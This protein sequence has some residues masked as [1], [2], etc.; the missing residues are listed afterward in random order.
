MFSPS[1]HAYLPKS[2]QIHRAGLSVVRPLSCNAARYSRGEPIAMLRALAIAGFMLVSCHAFGQ[3]A[4]TRPEFEVASIKLNKS[5]DP[6]V[7][8]MP[9]RGGRF[10]ATNIPLKFL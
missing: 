5:A 4:A 1:A 3:S 9:A 6:R 10:T 2:Q 7:M 8:V